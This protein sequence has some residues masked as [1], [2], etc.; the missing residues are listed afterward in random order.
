MHFTP[1]VNT[2]YENFEPFVG[3]LIRDAIQCS[4]IRA[5]SA[6]A[7]S[8]GT[9]ADKTM[10]SDSSAA[11]GSDES[12]S[13][14]KVQFRRFL[15]ELFK[16]TEI[17]YAFAFLDKGEDADNRVTEEEFTKN[18]KPFFD[19]IGFA[20]TEDDEGDHSAAMHEE[21]VAIAGEGA[22][23][24]GWES[25][26]EWF[27]SKITENALPNELG[28]WVQDDTEFALADQLALE[29]RPFD[30]DSLLDVL[31]VCHYNTRVSTST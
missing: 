15:F 9:Q 29:G 11:T 20:L 16:Y 25:I 28:L 5:Q 22:E 23:H 3:F 1:V 18:G 19:A 27:N 26:V 8:A 30:F 24:F 21:Y 14:T 7:A 31:M 13:I 2:A 17:Y 6:R 4:L 12:M 10:F